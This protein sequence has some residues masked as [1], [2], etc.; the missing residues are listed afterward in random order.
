LSPP[1]AFTAPRTVRL[2]DDRAGDDDSD[3]PAV[4]ADRR[5]A[6]VRRDLPP[7]LALDTVIGNA[8]FGETLSSYADM[9][10]KA[11]TQGASG[12]GGAE[13]LLQ[14]TLE[15]TGGATSPLGREV[16]ARLSLVRRFLLDL[17]GVR[18][19]SLLNTPEHRRIIVEAADDIRTRT[20]SLLGAGFVAD[21]P[22]GTLSYHVHNR[23]MA[24]RS[25]AAAQAARE[26]ARL[27]TLQAD[28]AQTIRDIESF[29]TTDNLPLAKRDAFV[30]DGRFDFESEEAMERFCPPGHYFDIPAP[31]LGA[32]RS[33][34]FGYDVESV[35]RVYVR[36]PDG[37][38]RNV[39]FEGPHWTYADE[40]RGTA[41]WPDP[42]GPRESNPHRHV[43]RHWST[44]SRIEDA[45]R[46]GPS[47]LFGRV[48]APLIDW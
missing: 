18:Y 40:D 14:R 10:W 36:Q 3:A 33:Y 28:K 12:L 24:E 1:A 11:R 6:R 13:Q 19:R 35:S 44:D 45:R 47:V 31:L 23:V 34:Y 46:W 29:W 42:T 4:E 5:S 41:S 27:R 21:N 32:A 20:L 43:N 7:R 15:Q 16:S 17:A 9:I 25:A 22:G 37:S 26:V 38:Y 2:L 8:T 48:A 30:D 39:N